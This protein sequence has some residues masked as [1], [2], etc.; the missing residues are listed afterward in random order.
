MK[1]NFVGIMIVSLICLGAS[2]YLYIDALSIIKETDQLCVGK[3][4]TEILQEAALHTK[5]ATLCFLVISGVMA[6]CSS[7]LIITSKK[8]KHFE[9]LNHPTQRE[10]F[11]DSFDDDF[12][13]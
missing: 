1:R 9:E 5:M 2:I 3:H 11:P 7:Y 13:N 10:A 6:V 4:A 8:Y 12:E